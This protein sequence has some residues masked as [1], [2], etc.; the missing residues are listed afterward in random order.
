MIDS[1][2]KYWPNNI[3][4]H[5]YAEKLNYKSSDSRIKIIDWD[6]VCFRDWEQFAKKTT[7][8]RAHRFGKKGWAS[9]HAWNNIEADYIIWLDADMLFSNFIDHSIIEKTINEDQLIGLFDTD[10]QRTEPVRKYWSAESGYVIVNKNHRVFNSF[11]KKYEGYYRSPEM[12]NGIVHWWDNEILMLAAKE[13]SEFVHDLSQYRTTNKTQTPLNRSFLS[14]Y[15]S[16]F[17]G[18]V[19][20]QNSIEMFTNYTKGQQ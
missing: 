8:N 4:L 6:H 2:L 9:L 16:H 15:M 14:D 12:P 13:F 1:W 19:K 7:D 18:Q 10:Y 20:K 17:K 11:I 5:L 3:D